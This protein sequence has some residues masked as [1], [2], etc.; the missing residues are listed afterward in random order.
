M[1][2]RTRAGGDPASGER[3]QPHSIASLL[4]GATFL[5]SDEGRAL[6]RGLGVDPQS[7]AA[8]HKPA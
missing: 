4:Q 7:A 8:W 2:R 5:G 3:Q 6:L 1:R